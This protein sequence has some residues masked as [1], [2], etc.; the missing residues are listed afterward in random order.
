MRVVV[1]LLPL[2]LGACGSVAPERAS[3]DA[4]VSESDAASSPVD[5]A[6][7]ESAAAPDAADAGWC[8]RSGAC[9]VF[10][11]DPQSDPH[12]CGTCG[13]DCGGGAC[14]AGQCVTLPPGV[15]ATGQHAPVAVA[16]DDTNVYW[17]N[18]GTYVSLGPKLASIYQGDGQLMKCALAGCN[19]HPTVVAD[20]TN[21]TL[22]GRTPSS[23]ALDA[24][25]VYWS[26]DGV[27][28]CAKDGCACAPNALTTNGSLGI[29]VT[30]SSF[31]WTGG[32]S[33]FTCALGGCTTPLV[34]AQN[35]VEP[36]GIVTDGA[37]VYWTTENGTLSS[38]ALGGCNAP[39]LV[40]AGAPES[41]QAATRSV[42][43][44]D[45]NLYWANSNPLKYG[46][47]MQ[48]AKSSCA[49]TLVTLADGRN[50]PNGVVADTKNVYWA[51]GNVYACAIG[52]CNDSPSVA[53][54]ASASAVAIDATHIYWAEV[55]SDSNDGRIMFAPKP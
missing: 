15:L 32:S 9:G 34:L 37:D 33:V 30:P 5:D 47:V 50:A 54:S 12:S 46:S 42:F 36:E 43:V 2:L 18:R 4:S 26:D 48:C 25:H 31:F 21:T 7:A 49:S 20:L 53:V 41:S 22:T 45:Q 19:N 13:H 10:A 6:S 8:P 29:A 51:E 27:Q 11:G 44:D 23:L 55:G 1:V 40:W 14:E 39:T 52:G 28:S 3:T 35:A 17:L 24:T 38:C 16:V